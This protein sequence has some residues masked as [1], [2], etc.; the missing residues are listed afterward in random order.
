MEKIKVSQWGEK[1]SLHFR[2]VYLIRVESWRPSDSSVLDSSFD[3]H[4]EVDVA[5]VLLI[6]EVDV[7]LHVNAGCHGRTWKPRICF[8]IWPSL[9][10]V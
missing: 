3:S 7:V 5:E 6:T 9:F 8:I 1:N 4:E 10:K 2:I